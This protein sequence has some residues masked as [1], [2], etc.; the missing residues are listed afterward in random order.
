M[1]LFIIKITNVLEVLYQKSMEKKILKNILFVFC[2]RKQI[3][4]VCNRMNLQLNHFPEYRTL[5]VNEETIDC[6][7]Y[8]QKD[9]ERNPAA[10]EAIQ[11]LSEDS[12]CLFVTDS[13]LF[14]REFAGRKPVVANVS[15]VGKTFP[16]A[17]YLIEEFSG[18]SLD[19]L[20]EAYCRMNQIPL[21]IGE[22]E[23]I[24][25]REMIPE[26]AAQLHSLYEEDEEL[27]YIEN[28]NAFGQTPEETAEYIR[29]DYSRRYAIW[30]YGMW[31][32]LA[33]ET[34]EIIGRVGFQDTEDENT[35]ELGYLVK[36][37]WRRRGIA[38]GACELSME[39]MKIKYPNLRI[40]CEI[41]E[42]NLPAI[43]LA[44][45]LKRIFSDMEI[46]YKRYP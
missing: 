13:E 20:K 15:K 43:A 18:D 9:Y 42:K 12:D 8:T 21:V 3:E 29:S 17:E 27:Y 46:V 10:Q 36:K 34:G 41:N 28:L 32:I 4:D 30:G 14:Y 44:K 35:V 37:R 25:I 1:L 6:I 26:D 22:N 19:Y 11:I 2:E 31:N 23:Q 39:Y 24:L 5:R 40:R 16:G 7:F 45:R 33:K 38:F